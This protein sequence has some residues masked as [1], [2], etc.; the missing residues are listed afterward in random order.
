[1]AHT[2]SLAQFLTV[3]RNASHAK[4]ESMTTKSS[5]LIACVAEILKTE[6]FIKDFRVIEEEGKQTIR[7]H[8]RYLKGGKPAIESIARVSK[9]G[10]RRYSPVDKLPRIK[11]GLG[12][13]IISTSRGVMTDSEA[14]KSNIG[15]EIL[16]KVC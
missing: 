2:D 12:I 16:C 3:L 5:K 10:L 14:R 15:G 1:M 6:R 11:S 9:P 4:H 13:A 8:L 7:V